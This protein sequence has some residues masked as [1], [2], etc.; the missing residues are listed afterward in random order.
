MDHGKI[1]GWRDARDRSLSDITRRKL[2]RQD[3][4][5]LD[6][7]IVGDDMAGRIP[8]E[9]RSGFDCSLLAVGIV[10][11]RRIGHLN[12]GRRHSIENGNSYPLMFR[13]LTT[14]F[15]RV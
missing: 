10:I 12:N 15:E 8:H 7:M 5:A 6:D 2:N 13:D 1:V 11:V 9:S 4:G 3:F 14:S